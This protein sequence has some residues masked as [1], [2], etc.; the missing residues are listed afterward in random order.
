MSL[1]FHPSQP[2]PAW[3]PYSEGHTNVT[4]IR[5]SNTLTVQAKPRNSPGISPQS[6]VKSWGIHC[7][8]SYNNPSTLTKILAAKEPTTLKPRKPCG[9]C[10]K[11]EAYPEAE[12]TQSDP[13]QRG[14]N[15]LPYLGGYKTKK[16]CVQ[17]EGGAV[18]ADLG[19]LGNRS[20]RA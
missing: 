8:Q 6:D 20:L 2:E 4:V 10:F 12:D 3:Y 17:A 19:C 5:H 9:R 18:Q 16:S 7:F 11:T 13:P 14:I 15:S 1:P